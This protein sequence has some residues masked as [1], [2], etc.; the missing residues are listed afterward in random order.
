MKKIALVGA[1]G[2]MG[3]RLTANLKK[4][5]YPMQYLEVSEPGISKLKELG[6]EISDTE[7]AIPAADIVILAV[8]DIILGKV[9]S[10]VVPKMKAGSMV[11][12][13][14]PAAALAKKILIRDDLSY[15]ISHPSH[16]S[17]FNWE[18]SPEAQADFFG[19]IR[20]K[21]TIVCALMQGNDSDYGEGEKLA[22]TMYA[23]V[24]KA[25]RITPEQMGLLEPALVETLAST[26]LTIVKE[27][28]DKVIE[29]GVPA[30]AA[31][32][33]LLGHLNI[34][35][36]VIFN[37][38]KGAVFSDAAKKAII[39]GRPVLFK[40]DWMKI[41]EPDNVMEQIRDIIT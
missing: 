12:T 22:C 8:P 9:S 28:L 6:L 10:S 36:A 19:G 31:R 7:K 13:L 24:S 5:E 35:L 25:F 33:F 14:D 38:L 15:F 17:V 2:K 40:D 4:S 11:V 29:L 16:P 32:E 21:Q 1:G 3:M 39:R 37:E 30:E 26:C 34:Q 23:P 20:A 27:G 18:P 41:F